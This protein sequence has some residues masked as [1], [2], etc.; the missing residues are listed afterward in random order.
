VDERADL[1]VGGEAQGRGPGHELDPARPSSA[2]NGGLDPVDLARRV[3]P[4]HRGAPTSSTR[5][6]ALAI[7]VALFAVL[8]LTGA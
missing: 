2:L 6:V 8:L 5:W 1:S 7:V 4:A 3:A